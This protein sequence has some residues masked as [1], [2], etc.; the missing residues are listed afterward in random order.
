[1]K[2][3][4][5]PPNAFSFFE[6]PLK[7][8]IFVPMA[9]EIINKVAQAQ[10]EQI[11]LFDFSVKTPLVGLDIKDQLWNELVLRE[12]DFRGWVKEHDWTQ[13][14][15]QIVHI[16]CSN[17]AIIPAWAFMLITAHLNDAENV[18]FGNAA[19]T[20]EQLFF[21]RLENWDVTH[22]TDKRVMVK[23]CSDIPNPNRAYTV[24]T[25]KLV[26]VVKNLMFGEPCS[27]VP[28][29]KKKRG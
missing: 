18:L 13:Y 7:T 16:Y 3:R 1:M 27:S 24:L 21:N 9:E 19:A 2:T 25:R 26:P 6:E 15:N 4:L 28:V 14:T 8:I 23:G 20:K 11:D 12:K 10:I 22:L 5:V 29:F 17:D